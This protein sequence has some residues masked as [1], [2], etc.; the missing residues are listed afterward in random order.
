MKSK[1]ITAFEAGGQRQS[2]VIGQITHGMSI[3]NATAVSS[4]CA[5]TGMTKHELHK[6]MFSVEPSMRSCGPG[7]DHGRGPPDGA[8]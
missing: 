3:R 6:R 1:L 4:F 5:L 7:H 2:R 8:R